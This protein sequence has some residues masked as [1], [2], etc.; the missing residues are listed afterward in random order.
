MKF[1]NTENLSNFHFFK[2][3][4]WIR[5]WTYGLEQM[6][7]VDHVGIKTGLYLIED[8]ISVQDNRK[9]N[10]SA[11][12]FRNKLI[13][14]NFDIWQRGTSQNIPGY[15]SDDRWFNSSNN[16]QM[17]FDTNQSDVPFNPS[18]YSRTILEQT[19]PQYDFLLDT[20]TEQP[21]LV[22]AYKEQRI[23]NVKLS[24]L[25][26][27]SNLSKTSNS[28]FTL[29]FWL[30]HNKLE[31]NNDGFISIQLIQHFG[32]G[33]NASPTKIVN[34]LNDNK[35]QVAIIPSNQWTQYVLNLE[36]ESLENMVI[37]G[38]DHYY[39][40]RF[41]YNLPANEHYNEFSKT[42]FDLAQVQLEPGFI[43][44]PFELR[45]IGLE[46]VLCQRYFEKQQKIHF[47]AGGGLETTFIDHV[48]FQTEKFKNGLVTIFNSNNLLTTVDYTTTTGFSYSITLSETQTVN[49]ILN[50]AITG[51][52]TLSKPISSFFDFMIDA[53]L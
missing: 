31:L 20:E 26:N 22:T 7:C 49:A 34:L 40:I 9:N 41:T 3:N 4:E 5:P 1:S 13:N 19:T 29:S 21:T 32:S 28:H 46:I 52:V 24:K 37:D 10:F 2:S 38:D 44:T 36:F 35:Q 27:F 8:N 16:T 14:G 6:I 39:G 25:D 48:C 15:G 11:F 43:Y 18:Y 47:S 53:E 50:S 17:K 51:V 42:A 45:P 33:I 23:E 12:T 30:K